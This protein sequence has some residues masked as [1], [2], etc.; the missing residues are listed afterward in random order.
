MPSFVDDMWGYL[1]LL[2]NSIS[3][4]GVRIILA[5]KRP[6]FGSV[7]KNVLKL[8]A[9]LDIIKSCGGFFVLGHRR[10]Q[11]PDGGCRRVADIQSSKERPF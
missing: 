8:E 1:H 2:A 10:A 6:F 9:Y 4:A 7:A 5:P 3:Q 11:F